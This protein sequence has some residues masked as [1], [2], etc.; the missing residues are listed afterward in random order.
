MP[1]TDLLIALAVVAYIC[2]KQLTWRP[3][4]P[5]RMWRMPLIL[6]AVGV[7]SLTGRHVPLRPVDV[8]V[9]GLSAVLAL[10]SGALMGRIARFRRSP[11]NPAVVETRTGGAGVA[12]WAGLIAIRVVIDVAGHRMGSDLAVST[13][14]ILLVLAL[15]RA[16]GALVVSARRPRGE[17]ALAGR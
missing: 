6:G 4:D 1:V 2:A 3:A 10:A 14:S 15:N 5:G 9:L 12:I 7:V 8:V 16:A 11:V 17:Y 13:G